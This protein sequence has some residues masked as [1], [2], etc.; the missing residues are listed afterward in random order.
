MLQAGKLKPRISHQYPLAQAA[1]A[2]NDILQRKVTG[3]AV[4]VV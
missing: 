3:K 2:L 1:D 4:L